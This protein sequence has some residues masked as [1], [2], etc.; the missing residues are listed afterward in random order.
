M[1][2]MDL[3]EFYR[4]FHPSTREYTF[5]SAAQKKYYKIEDMLGYKT[6]NKLREIEIVIGPIQLHDNKI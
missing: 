6:D 4:I 1:K 2:Q 3:I 5:Y